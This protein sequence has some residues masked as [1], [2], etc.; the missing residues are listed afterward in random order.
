[1]HSNSDK[2][3]SPPGRLQEQVKAEGIAADAGRNLCTQEVIPYIPLQRQ[4]R[5]GLLLD[6]LFSPAGNSVC[7]FLDFFLLGENRL[8]VIVADF[9]DELVQD[10]LPLLRL[11]VRSKS[12]SRCAAATLRYLDERLAECSSRSPAATAAYLIFDQGK[13]LL[14]FA[15]A[16][17]LP[18]LLHRPAENQTYLLTAPGAP[19]GH[20]SDGDGADPD[21]SAVHRINSESIALCT[22]DLVV[23]HNHGLVD[24]HNGRGECFGRERLVDFLRKYGELNPSSLLVE[25]QRQLDAFAEGRQETETVAVVAVKNIQRDLRR[26]QAEHREFDIAGRFLCAEDE[27]I[28]LATLREFP[29]A[30]ISEIAARLAA[31]GHGRLNRRQLVAYLLQTRGWRPAGRMA[32]VLSGPNRASANVDEHGEVF[33]ALARSQPSDTA[34]KS[35]Q[36]LLAAFPARQV[37]QRAFDFRDENALLGRALRCY[38]SGD[39]QG[40]LF[41][42]SRVRERLK[43]SAAVHCFSGNLYLALN[44]IAKAKQEYLLALKSDQRSAHAH[45]ALGYVALLQEDHYTAIDELSTALRLDQN[46]Q[47]HSSVLQK[48]I[49]VVER[50]EKRNGWLV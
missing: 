43:D 8:G 32:H 15:S 13:R 48:L 14:H 2:M 10:G 21:I 4:E 1:M 24:Q 35:Q 22:G 44:M 18:V 23:L 12:A 39:C 7:D 33:S 42:L 17:H 36:A 41:E 3:P 20:D 46:L 16:G 28:V 5:S 34:K 29:R 50:R 26:P 6:Y 47:A 37:L 45:L 30:S 25:L 38:G 40:A 19:L 11:A 31:G 9:A 27:Q 49:A